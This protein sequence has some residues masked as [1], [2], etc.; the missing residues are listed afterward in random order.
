[1]V[2]LMVIIGDDD[3]DDYD[4]NGDDGISHDDYVSVRTTTAVPSDGNDNVDG[5]NDGDD[6]ND[7]NDDD[8]DVSL[9]TTTAVPSEPAPGTAMV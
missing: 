7:G 6:D 2:I 9:R 4:G 8:E 3:Y 1:M 5:G